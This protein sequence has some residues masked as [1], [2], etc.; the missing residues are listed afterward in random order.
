MK[1]K[2]TTIANQ[3][4]PARIA[5]LLKPFLDPAILLPQQLEQISTYIDIL[6]RW[7]ARINLTAIRHPEEIVTRHFGESLFT[8]QHLFPSVLAN[9]QRPK[10][11]DQAPKTNDAVD[12]GSGAGFPGLPLKIWAPNLQVTLIESNQKKATFLREVIRTLTLTNINVFP[13]RA[14]DYPTKANVV[15]LRAV[16]HFAAT[17]P[18]AANLVAPNGR[19][20]LLI[21]QAQ[22]AQLP[23]LAPTFHWPPP[24]PIPLSSNRILLVGNLPRQNQP[25][26][27]A[28]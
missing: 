13:N 23:T 22:A 25:D 16:E 18:A 14:Q 15:T 8:A 6:L 27:V 3:M 24:I 9:D 2:S 5:E 7:N 19:L 4:T 17:V 12:I 21:G 20:A 11:N 28:T 1:P 10:T 26:Q